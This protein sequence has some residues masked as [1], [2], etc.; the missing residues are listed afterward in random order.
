MTVGSLRVGTTSVDQVGMSAGS[1]FG[2]GTRLAAFGSTNGDRAYARTPSP[3]SDTG[4]NATDFVMTTPSG[5][6]NLASVPGCAAPVID[7][8]DAVIS[9]VYGGGGNSGSVFTNDFIE[10][11][12]SMTGMSMCSASSAA[13]R[14]DRSRWLTGRRL[15]SI[16]TS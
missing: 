4:D 10:I 2:E 5:P 3:G 7:Q 6:Q 16:P 12:R 8:G 14:L 15:V 9:Q 11:F 13:I 1:A